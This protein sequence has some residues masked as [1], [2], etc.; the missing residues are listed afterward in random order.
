MNATCGCGQGNKEH[1]CPNHYSWELWTVRKSQQ[2]ALI[3]E[4]WSLAVIMSWLNLSLS[5]A[6]LSFTCGVQRIYTFKRLSLLYL[7]LD[8]QC[9]G[10]AIK[11]KHDSS[12]YYVD[13]R[14]TSKKTDKD[15]GYY[16]RIDQ[17]TLPFIYIDNESATIFW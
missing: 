15:D 9:G 1:P 14:I 12:K 16:R 13:R 10:Y 7:M 4:L 3:N 17:S 11:H 8:Y 5:V 6:R 2:A